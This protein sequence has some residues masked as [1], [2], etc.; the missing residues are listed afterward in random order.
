MKTKL[1]QK[2]IR[3]QA[4]LLFF[5]TFFLVELCAG[6][7]YQNQLKEAIAVKPLSCRIQSDETHD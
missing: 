3:F 4:L 5:I 1:T 2:Q 7:L 6:F